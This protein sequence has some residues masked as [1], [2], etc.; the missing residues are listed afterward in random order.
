MKKIEEN[1]NNILNYIASYLI[2]NASYMPEL[3]L[4]HGKMGVSLFFAYY[5]RYTENKQYND[6][7]GLLLDEVFE[8][9]TREISIDFENGLAGIGWSI[10]YLVQ[11]GF[12]Q[13]D[14]TLVLEDLNQCILE[15][16]PLR[17]KDHSFWN[18]LSGIA[19]YVIYHTGSVPDSCFVKDET[20]MPNLDVALKKA[21]LSDN[22]EYNKI[23]SFSSLTSFPFLYPL[24]E[25][26]SAITLD[27]DLSALPLGIEKGIAGYGLKLLQI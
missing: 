2:I 26:I 20:Y 8:D 12:M 14:T 11:Q 22:D 25:N 9:F 16:E 4:Y 27:T 10:E 7:A 15:R 17:I 18:G 19:Y 13:G 5:G 21:Q 1:I 3:G 24:V 6:F 23:N